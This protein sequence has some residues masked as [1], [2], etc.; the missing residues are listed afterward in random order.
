MKKVISAILF[1][2][3]LFSFNASASLIGDDIFIACT[4]SSGSPDPACEGLGLVPATVTNNVEYP[5]FFNFQ[6]SISI[7]VLANSIEVAF[8][9]GPYC[10]WFTCDGQGFL[11]FDLT[12][13]DWISM[14][15]S[16]I[17]SLDVVTNMTGVL[18]SFGP[19]SVSFSL[20]ETQVTNDMFLTINLITAAIPEPSVFLVLLMLIIGSTAYRM[21]KQW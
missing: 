8:E 16:F 12:D 2:T 15:T 11:Q 17:S 18:T 21:K 19:D 10:G 13:L 7:D 5:D 1:M 9:N 3:A 14:P 4:Q 6:N 20:P